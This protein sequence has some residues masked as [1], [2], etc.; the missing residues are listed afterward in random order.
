MKLEQVSGSTQ[1]TMNKRSLR[2]NK[3][4]N[5]GGYKQTD[6]HYVRNLGKETSDKME[7]GEKNV[8]EQRR[9]KWT[10]YTNLNMWLNKCEEVLIDI[11]FARLNI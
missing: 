10:T 6:L 2:K 5:K 7:I 3:F 11:G 4:L 8:L 9:A 1:S